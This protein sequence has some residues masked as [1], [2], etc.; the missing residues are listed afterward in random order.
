[1]SSHSKINETRGH[2]DSIRDT[3]ESHGTSFETLN[4]QSGRK[5]IMDGV[6]ING[7][8]SGLYGADDANAQLLDKEYENV[9][10]YPES[11]DYYSLLALP[12]DPPPTEAQ[13][14]S[15]YRSLT[16]S[17]HPD[18]QPPELREAATRHYHRIQTAYDTLIDPKKRVVYD[19]LGAEGV[20][21]EWQAGGTMGVHGL[22]EKQD[23]GV[24]TMDTQQFRRWFLT[25]MKQRERKAL[26]DMI[27]AKVGFF[28]PFF[29]WGRMSIKDCLTFL[30]AFIVFLWMP[31]IFLFSSCEDNGL[32]RRVDFVCKR[33]CITS[34][35]R[36]KKNPLL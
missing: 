7:P 1:M 26:E 32:F 29:F 3:A 15:A 24:K 12:R 27:Q 33:L 13:I 9:L 34:E 28:F 35:K 25:I 36:E 19:Y 10:N 18:K 20:E 30:P 5:H 8:P 21:T 16:L 2:D 14:R 23:V 22:A 6:N 17:F 11:I 4:G 31:S